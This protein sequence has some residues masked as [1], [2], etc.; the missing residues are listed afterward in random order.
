MKNKL[1]AIGVSIFML[2]T[3][4]TV[5]AIPVGS[6]PEKSL[7]LKLPNNEAKNWKEL[8]R[9]ITN[10]AGIIEYI[11]VDQTS[12]NWSKI[13][14]I[15]F[16][17]EK[18]YAPIGMV[19]D[20][21]RDEVIAAHPNCKVIWKV[22]E[23]NERDFLY[24]WIVHEPNQNAPYHAIGRMFI[25]NK[26]THRI[27][28]DHQHEKMSGDERKK[29]IRLL[30]ES[31]SLVSFED[32]SSTLDGLSMGDW[33]KDSLNLGPIF[34]NWSK[35]RIYSMDSYTSVCHI[36]PIHDGNYTERLETII[37]EVDCDSVDP[38]FAI[39]K[40]VIREKNIHNEVKF[41][42]LKKTPDEIIYYYSHPKD[43]VQLTA[44]VRTFIHERKYYSLMYKHELPE[45]MK[46]EDVLQWAKRL[47]TIAIDDRVK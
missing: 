27:G 5:N 37:S 8:V 35:V 33:F 44:V 40:D 22:I 3:H 26:G 4:G 38:L 14:N 42:I 30:K 16:L 29:L 47:Q 20:R 10:Q 24:E 18:I 46:K 36:P 32:I 12:Q 25:T 23:K 2:L 1:F 19:L 15:Q 13:I 43:Q 39:E 9:N 31:V 11:P 28:I 34:Q 6:P 7:L 21:I 45:E 41:H 17:E